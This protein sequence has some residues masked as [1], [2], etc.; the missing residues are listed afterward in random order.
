ML[1]KFG[2]Y[3]G[4]LAILF[5]LGAGLFYYKRIPVP[6]RLLVFQALAAATFELWGTISVQLFPG[7]SNQIYFNF[8]LPIDF[9][10]MLFAARNALGK[11][12][13]TFAIAGTIGFLLSWIFS[14]A[15]AG[16][17]TLAWPAMICYAI[18]LT[19]AYFIVL[20]RN[21]QQ[22]GGRHT[23]GLYFIAVSVMLYYCC[24]I[25]TFGLMDYLFKKD[26]KLATNLFS[27]NHGLNVLR[28][29]CTGIGLMLMATHA[30]SLQH[31]NK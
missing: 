17:N 14:V 19:I 4:L 5:C 25:P 30:S 20:L 2:I 26:M 12:F 16:I 22:P 10:L 23:T 24:T 29:F 11:H 9:F 15:R 3:A 1:L 27:I 28:Y 21:S 18:I 8:Y 6:Y 31:A 7:R 13:R